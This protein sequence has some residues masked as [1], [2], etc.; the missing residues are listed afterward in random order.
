MNSVYKMHKKLTF[1]VGIDKSREC[2]L[3]AKK[4]EYAWKNVGKLMR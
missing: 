3:Q 1:E 4:V 2:F